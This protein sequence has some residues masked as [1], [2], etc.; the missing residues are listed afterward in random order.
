LRSL[1]VPPSLTLNWKGEIQISRQ[2]YPIRLGKLRGI[3]K[4]GG[5]AGASSAGGKGI[6]SCTENKEIS[7]AVSECGIVAKI[8]K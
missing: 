4:I 3:T 7:E 1:S 2:E 6:A 5:R 8:V